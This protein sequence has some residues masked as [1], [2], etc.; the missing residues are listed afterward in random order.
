MSLPIPLLQAQR[1][2]SRLT[3]GLGSMHTQGGETW[4]TFWK[5]CRGVESIFLKPDEPE[6]AL[7]W[8]LIG[9][10]LHWPGGTVATTL[11]LVLM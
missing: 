10:E 11:Q 5:P 9:L 8:S 3:S 1:V 6:A 2:F 4:R 7:A